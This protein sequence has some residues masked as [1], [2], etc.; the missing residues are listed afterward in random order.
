MHKRYFLARLL[1]ISLALILLFGSPAYALLTSPHYE[2]NEDF[3][4]SGGVLNTCSAAYCS[5]QALGELGVGNVTSPNFQANG[6]FNTTNTPLLTMSVAGG[7]F[8][9][10][11]LSTG[12]TNSISTTFSVE[13]YISDG[14][15]VELA[16]TTLNDST[17]SY[18]FH[19]FTSPT[20]ATPGTEQFGVN[21]AANTS[22]SVG[23]VPNQIPN[24]TF[25]FGHVAHNYNEGGGRT[26][27]SYD[28]VNN[29]LFDSGDVVAFSNSS[30]GQT[31]YTLSVIADQ[32]GSTPAGQY[33]TTL[34]IIAV[35]SF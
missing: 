11:I 28:S 5:K 7:T 4:G 3:F 12:A 29:F 25:S 27:I 31:A 35:P 24:S 15:V 6:G 22:P 34:N 33:G 1:A 18:P 30:S 8:D 16:G 17:N 9:L 10:G 14:Y 20:A 26:S 19:T 21:L 23:A 32:S 2:V 13:N